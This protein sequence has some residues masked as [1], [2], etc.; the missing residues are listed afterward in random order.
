MKSKLYK[1]FINW[2]SNQENNSPPLTHPL[3]LKTIA[4]LLLFNLFS[5]VYIKSLVDVLFTLL[6]VTC[7][8]TFVPTIR[9]V[10]VLTRTVLV[11]IPLASGF[12]FVDL[13]TEYLVIKSSTILGLIF[14][15]F[16]L[17]FYWKDSKILLNKT[18]LSITPKF[19]TKWYISMFY[20]LLITGPVLEEFYF[21]VFISTVLNEFFGQ[22]IA[23]TVSSLLF[24]GY[25]L[26]Q[27]EGI[28]KF[29]WKDSFFRFL[30]GIVNSF[31]FLE[32]QT[33]T[34]C[35]FA[36]LTF[37]SISLLRVILLLIRK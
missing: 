30:L 35:I 7:A 37:N 8:L 27:R 9:R 23:V 24:V 36:H 1:L 22:T 28:R 10:S 26:I 18:I 17:S 5:F 33:I 31:I 25:H 21:R 29:K 2:N 34:F 12:L 14:G 32:Y 4:I 11:S 15:I 13:S 16:L 6:I 19:N 3:Q 20:T